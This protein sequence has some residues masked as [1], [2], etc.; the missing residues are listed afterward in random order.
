MIICPECGSSELKVDIPA[1]FVIVQEP[2]GIWVAR[3]Y[4][5]TYDP[6][7]W[8]CDDC[9]HEWEDWFT[10]PYLDEDAPEGDK[11]S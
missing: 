8:H 6:A 11:P 2:T 10:E 7:S 5:D 3:G 9:G 4:D 1:C